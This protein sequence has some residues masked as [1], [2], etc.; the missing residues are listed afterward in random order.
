M[1]CFGSCDEDTDS[2]RISSLGKEDGVGLRRRLE[3]MKGG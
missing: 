3:T 2:M 1:A